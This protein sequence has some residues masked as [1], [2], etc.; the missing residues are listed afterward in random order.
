MPPLSF[1]AVNVTTGMSVLTTTTVTFALTLF[2]FAVYVY[3]YTNVPAAEPA[4]TNN[5]VLVEMFRAG[6]DAF[7]VCDT[8]LQLYEL[9]LT[10]FATVA[11]S[12]YERTVVAFEGAVIVTTGSSTM[13]VSWI[14]VVDTCVLSRPVAVTVAV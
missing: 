8:Q 1:P 13:Y 6:H 10:G 5:N 11:A 2:A 12:V 3:V 9:A 7:T 4:E 14:A